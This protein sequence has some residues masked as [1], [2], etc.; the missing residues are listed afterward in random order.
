MM[1]QGTSPNR[2]D[3]IPRAVIFSIRVDT[4]PMY[5]MKEKVR[6]VVEREVL[7]TASKGLIR[8]S[9]PCGRGDQCF[10]QELVECS[11]AGPALRWTSGGVHGYEGTP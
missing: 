10:T 5:E 9:R 8:S 4:Y 7:L 1:R 3:M 2:K 11:L 6:R